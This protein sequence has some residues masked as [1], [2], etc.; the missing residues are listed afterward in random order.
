MAFEWSYWKQSIGH[1]LGMNVMND[2][3]ATQSNM[4]WQLKNGLLILP[5]K[6]SI[7]KDRGFSSSVNM[8]SVHL[9]V[10]IEYVSDESEAISISVRGPGSRI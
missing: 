7:N 4:I 8:A 3:V 6:V 5:V 1:Y 9:H 2:S 10:C